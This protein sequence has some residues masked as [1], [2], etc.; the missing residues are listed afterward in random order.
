[1]IYNESAPLMQEPNKLTY[2]LCSC[3]D[4][5]GVCCDVMWCSPCLLGRTYDAI[6]LNK[7]NSMNVGVCMGVSLAY[8][9]G[10]AG[11]VYVNLV[12]GLA[13]FGNAAYALGCLPYTYVACR[14][15]GVIKERMNVQK[16]LCEDFMLSWCITGCVQCQM[17]REAN[18]L[19]M[20]PG[21]ICCCS[22]EPPTVVVAQQMVQPAYPYGSSAHW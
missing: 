18:R 4:D 3:F 6:I 17:T 10:T 12:L 16:N 15:R 14:Q 11:A 7:P 22:S 19:G 5:M 20:Q 9:A 8:L 1:M 2:G 21:T 13:P